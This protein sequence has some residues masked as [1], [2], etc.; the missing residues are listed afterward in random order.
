MELLY[1]KEGYIVDVEGGRVLHD[2]G[3]HS[4]TFDFENMICFTN[5]RKSTPQAIR[6]DGD[7]DCIRYWASGRWQ[8]FESDKNKAVTSL[9]HTYQEYKML[10]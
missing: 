5:G 8:H 3:G 7:N 9:F 10:S 6:Y 4:S 1:I 2:K